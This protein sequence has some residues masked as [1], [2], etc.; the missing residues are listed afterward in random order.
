[1]EPVFEY[2]PI[3]SPSGSALTVAF[4]RGLSTRHGAGVTDHGRLYGTISGATLTLFADVA[5]SRAVLSGSSSGSGYFDLSEVNSSGM[6]GR[7]SMGSSS[8]TDLI[9]V[10]SFA[11]DQDVMLAESS[12]SRMPGWDP[13]YGLA[14]VHAAAMRWIIT[15]ALPA[16]VPHLFGGRGAAGF[17]PNQAGAALPDLK[18]LANADHLRV[19]QADLVKALSARESEHVPEWADVMRAAFERFNAT[20]DAL[21]VINKKEEIAAET[22]VAQLPGMT[23]SS[24]RRG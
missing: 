14:G 7:A 10:A 16:K 19:A 5:K 4:I 8:E 24:W 20:M 12:V 6:S 1:M 11:D 23:V 15:T 13:V 3:L 18:L 22:H 2:I 9:L 21:A 17:V